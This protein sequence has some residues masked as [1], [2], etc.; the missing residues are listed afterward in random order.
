MP[1]MGEAL[2]GREKEVLRLVAT[3]AT[4]EQIARELVISTNTVKVHLRNIFTKLGVASRTEATLHAVRQGWVTLETS[5]PA[6]VEEQ[7]KE[8]AAESPPRRARS[9]LLWSL[10]VV[11]AGL[12]VVALAVLLNLSGV[13]DGVRPTPAQSSPS[14]GTSPAGQRWSMLADMPTPRSDL[15]L[16]AF[17]GSLYAIGGYGPDGATAATERF[18]SV[19]NAWT[20]L[21]PKP[22][23]VGE[24]QAAVLGGHIYIPG[25]CVAEGRPTAVTEVYLIERNQWVAAA[26]LPRAL[27][28][29]ALAS[30]EGKI[31]LFG[32]WDGS[33]YRQEILRYDAEADR[34]DEAGR[35]PFPVGHAGAVVVDDHVLLIG[36]VNADGPVNVVS[37]Y[38]PA[39]STVSPQPLIG[40]SL[41]RVRATILF[42]DYLYALADPDTTS[43]PVLWQHHVRGESWQTT[44]QPLDGFAPGAALAGIG[45]ELFV[46]GGRGGTGP[47]SQS[48]EYRALFVVTPLPA[49][50]PW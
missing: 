23:A 7:E 28:A 18:D 46:V 33:A 11:L 50:G 45:T 34:W 25:G 15:A 32:G 38:S 48:R 44:D 43:S 27:S 12:A 36:G 42:G 31:Y 24:A 26:A 13:F 22:T 17:Q 47:V 2:S 41:G 5:P 37:A 49:P 3:G 35:L 39:F 8:A 29:Y 4:N 30:F 6:A 14:T 20:S 9:A 1:E 10:G 19:G 21:A 16:V 40:V